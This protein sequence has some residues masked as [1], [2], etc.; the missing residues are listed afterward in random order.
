[1]RQESVGIAEV[2]IRGGT[3]GEA[4]SSGLKIGDFDQAFQ[5]RLRLEPFIGS[6]EEVRLAGWYS[7]NCLGRVRER[8]Q[9]VE[10]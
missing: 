4:R 7:R 3:V 9:I 6:Y 8:I 2:D 1:M 5:T 10:C